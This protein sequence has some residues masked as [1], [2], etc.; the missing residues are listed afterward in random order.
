[1]VEGGEGADCC[2]GNR[3]GGDCVRGGGESQTDEYARP[4]VISTACR[5]F[6][7]TKRL[8]RSI[9]PVLTKFV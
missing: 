3:A 1:M 5:D 7:G 2:G 9:S 4:R 8:N 6:K